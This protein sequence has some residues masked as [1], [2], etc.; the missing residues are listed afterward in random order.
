MSGLT[1]PATPAVMGD[2]K[3]MWKAAPLGPNG[4][5]QGPSQPPPAGEPGMGG[6]GPGAG[7]AGVTASER[8][9]QRVQQSDPDALLAEFLQVALLAELPIYGHVP[10]EFLQVDGGGVLAARS[11]ERG[12]EM[13]GACRRRGKSCLLCS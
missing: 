7:P 10:A 13:V 4:M 2:G 12:K 3:A 5:P 9:A 8:R 11:L 1:P 6:L